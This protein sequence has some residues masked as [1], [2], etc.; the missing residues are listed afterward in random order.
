MEN[1]SFLNL[2]YI[3]VQFFQF[4]QSANDT[5]GVSS[6]SLGD[7][8]GSLVQAVVILGM[9][10][11]LLFIVLIVY[12]QIRLLQVEHHGFHALEEKERAAHA[13]ET[14][15]EGGNERWNHVVA[16]AAASSPGDWRRAILEAD[17]MLGEILTEQGYRGV[18]VGE[19]LK[20]ANPL[21]MT[22][23][24]LAWKAHKV[25]NE[26]AHG[27]EAYA[28]TERDVRTTID[29]YRRVFEEFGAI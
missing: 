13:E 1:A 26:V 5:T 8:F 27:G 6:G 21:Q 11:S 29:Y 25:R 9:V 12:A 20:D 17:I 3:L 28:L 24:D 2:E 7:T 16:L 18:G 10:L 15:H 14:E 23:L 22:T 19:Q 4:L